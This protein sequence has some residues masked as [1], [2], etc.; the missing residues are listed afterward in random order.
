MSTD[1]LIFNDHYLRDESIRLLI[2]VWNCQIDCTYT[3]FF[4]VRAKVAAEVAC[5]IRAKGRN[6]YILYE[7]SIK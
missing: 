7:S 5:L 1:F 3:A 4:V 6:C 2:M